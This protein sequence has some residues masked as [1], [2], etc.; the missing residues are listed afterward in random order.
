MGMMIGRSGSADGGEPGTD[1]TARP[2]GR[3]VPAVPKVFSAVALVAVA[4][5][6]LGVA[7]FGLRSYNLV[8][9]AAGE[10]KLLAFQASP[11]APDGW[12]YRISNQYDW[13]KPLFG[14]DST[15]LRYVFVPSG[16]GGDLR[17]TYGVTADII[18]TSDLETFSAY[19]VED[20]YQFHGYAL[21]DVAQVDIGGGI[22]GQSLSFS[23][24]G[25]QSWSVVYWI[26]PVKAGQGVRYERYVLYLLNAPG[27]AGIHVPRD[28]HITNLAGSLAKTGPDV[29]L[30]QNRAF[31]VAFAHELVV[32][33]A[34]KASIAK[35][36]LAM[37]RN[38]PPPRL[39]ATGVALGPGTSTARSSA[40]AAEA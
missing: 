22:T 16:G 35:G 23:G 21:R 12:R 6:V 31:L 1:V 38:T 7:D 10:P 5:L 40:P 26:A 32:D 13:A 4:T 37:R 17:S 29:V 24:A 33:Q 18:D 28:V 15:W 8:A 27:G 3:G 20:C 34:L 30:A 36:H 25:Q 19:G 14:D 39:V 2:L 11:T 9:N